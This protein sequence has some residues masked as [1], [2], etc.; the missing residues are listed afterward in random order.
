MLCKKEG[1]DIKSAGLR[2]TSS[3]EYLKETGTYFSDF[4]IYG[5]D[6]PRQTR[7]D[8]SS[9]GFAH[10]GDLQIQFMENDKNKP[11]AFLDSFTP[12][13]KRPADHSVIILEKEIRC[14]NG[15]V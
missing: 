11:F 5:I 7:R 2:L 13:L 9:F 15:K 6:H 8:C 14:M 1:P 12:A 4:P 3:E 10:R